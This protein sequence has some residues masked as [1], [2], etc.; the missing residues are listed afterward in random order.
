MRAIV[1]GGGV[2]GLAVA[3]AL[4]RRGTDVVL[5]EREPLAGSGATGRN[6]GAIRSGFDSELNTALTMASLPLLDEVAGRAD[7]D[8]RFNRHG[9]L[10]LA[11]TAVQEQGLRV[12]VERLRERGGAAQWLSAAS[13]VR[14]VPPLDAGRLR[15]AALFS[16]DGY[17]DPHALATALLR[18]AIRSGAAIRCGVAVSSIAPGAGATW[19]SV[20]TDGTV[21]ADV[22]VVAA[23]A[24]SGPLMRGLGVEVPLVP[25]RRHSFV[26]GPAEWFPS[27]APFVV[28]AATGAYFRPLG[29]SLMFGRGR[30]YEEDATS[31]S[32]D[33]APDALARAVAAAAEVVPAVER[34]TVRFGVAGPYQ[35]TPDLHAVVGPVEAHPGLYLACGFSGHGLMHAP[36]TGRLVAEWILD[37]TPVSLPAARA[38]VLERFARGETLAERMQI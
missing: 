3:D 8:L 18:S 2:V 6:P 11:S 26:T 37:G 7:V 34:A 27:D 33:V 16:R 1:V 13:A 36:I 9:Y 17:L 23:G 38:L 14:R 12:V 29:G 19:E 22:V 28:D 35:M 25:Y 15:G 30:E 32:L 10:W 21:E 24:W 31:F 4:A 20:T 5:L